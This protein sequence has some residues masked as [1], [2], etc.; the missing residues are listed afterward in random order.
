MVNTHQPSLP[1]RVAAVLAAHD[2]NR[3]GRK[4]LRFNLPKGEPKTTGIHKGQNEVS[5]ALR[6]TLRTFERNGWITRADRQVLI[7]N[8]QALAGYATAAHTRA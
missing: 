4:T 8:R 2:G 6:C 5:L 1:R 3:I 7:V